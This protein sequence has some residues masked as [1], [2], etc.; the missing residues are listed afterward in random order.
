MPQE[1]WFVFDLGNTV[2]KLAYERVLENICRNASMKRD[3]LVE[4]LEKPGGYR[5][6]ES[7]AIA[8]A[9]FYEFLC[10]KAGY[11]GSLR[12]LKAV[13]ADFFAGPMPGIEDLLERVRERYRVAFL[14]NSNEV[15]AEVIPR[16]FAALFRRDDRFVFS[17]R[18]HCA[19]PDPEIFR[20]TLE[21]IGALPQHAVFIDDLI[22]NVIAARALGMTAYQYRDAL[23]LTGELERDE[24]L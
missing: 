23:S 17:H 12:E 11:R 10:D 9:D 5:D 3:A 7:G 8:F 16:Q 24:L 4:L 20:R 19:K 1:T 2:I 13:W 21:V 14:S 15:H 22:E 18:F 6:L